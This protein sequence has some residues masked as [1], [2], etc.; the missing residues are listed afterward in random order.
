[1]AGLRIF[2]YAEEMNNFTIPLFRVGSYFSDSGYCIQECNTIC[3]FGGRGTFHDA[4]SS[5]ER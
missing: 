5:F 2:S 3:V 4:F 1:M